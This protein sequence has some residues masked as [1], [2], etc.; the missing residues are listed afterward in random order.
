MPSRLPPPLIRGF[1]FFKKKGLE[2]GLENKLQTEA[3]STV[4]CV[5]NWFS[6]HVSHRCWNQNPLMFVIR[7][8][9]GSL[10][11]PPSGGQQRGRPA[12]WSGLCFKSDRCFWT[13][14]S[15]SWWDHSGAL[16][17]LLLSCLM[18]TLAPW[19]SRIR[20]IHFDRCPMSQL[21]D[22]SPW[23]QTVRKRSHLLWSR[24]CF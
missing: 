11:Q 8:S 16:S 5:L 6:F 17:S 24:A 3:K 1:F 18:Y 19:L 12:G 23:K 15:H 20:V 9:R 22:C 2:V 10:R 14:N 21:Y 13:R 4:F 7:H